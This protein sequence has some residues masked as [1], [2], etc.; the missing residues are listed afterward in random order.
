MHAFST[1]LVNVSALQNQIMHPSHWL[2]QVSVAE[3]ISLFYHTFMIRPLL[4]IWIQVRIILQ[5]Q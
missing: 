1:E 4:D 5:F 3:P 2:E